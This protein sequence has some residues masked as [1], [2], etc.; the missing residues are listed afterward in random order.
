MAD[1]VID[2]WLWSDLSGENA[3][4]R[5]KEA[6][7][8]LRAVFNKCDRIVTVKGSKFEQKAMR[9]WRQADVMQDLTCRKIAKFLKGSFWYNS[10]KTLL[11]DENQLQDPLA[12]VGIK[13]DDQYLLQAYLTAQASVIVTTDNPLRDLLASH[14]IVCEKRDDFVPDY[15]S[16]YWKE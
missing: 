8:F 7:K 6:F 12:G 4:E 5:Q 16:R 11:L 3:T 9:L 15:I 13:A 14:G 2:E 1:L 10:D